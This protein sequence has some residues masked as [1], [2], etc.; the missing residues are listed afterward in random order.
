MANKDWPCGFHPAYG[1]DGGLPVVEYYPLKQSGAYGTAIFQGQP[2]TWQNTAGYLL[3]C[4]VTNPANV[5]GVAANYFKASGTA[6]QLAVWPTDKNIFTAQID[7][8]TAIT[9]A[10]VQNRN[11]VLINMTAGNTSTGLS[12]C[13]IDATRGTYIGTVVD[14]VVRVLGATKEIG[15]SAGAN[16]KVLCVFAFGHTPRSVAA[17]P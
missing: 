7:T 3:N 9:L 15:E 8:D 17:A 4:A 14:K 13:Q 1:I 10:Q 5:L 6:T 11:F 2:V 12:G 16:M